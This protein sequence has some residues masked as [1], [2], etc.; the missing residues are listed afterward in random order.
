MIN[1]Q[2]FCQSLDKTQ[3]D[4]GI[5]DKEFQPRLILYCAQSRVADVVELVLQTRI[6]ILL[7][8]DDIALLRGIDLNAGARKL[9]KNTRGECTPE[10]SLE[11]ARFEN[12]VR[13]NV[14]EHCAV[15]EDARRIDGDALKVGESSFRG[16]SRRNGKSSSRRRK[17]VQ[18]L[19]ILLG[20]ALITRDERTVQ[21][22][23]QEDIVVSFF[24]HN[25]SM[26]VR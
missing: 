6:I 5:A 26:S 13:C 17:R 23:D 21:I 22:A 12:L 7:G 14:F 15:E 4:G 25:A 10:I 2:L 8:A 19:Q 3:V 1:A 24:T 11:C 9:I 18:C 16:A 20:D